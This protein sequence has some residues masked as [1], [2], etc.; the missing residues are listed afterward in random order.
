M[1]MRGEDKAGASRL[2]LALGAGLA[3]AA[4]AVIVICVARLLGPGDPGES[5]PRAVTGPDE[6]PPEAVAA[7]P[8]EPVSAVPA[9]PAPPDPEA[10]ETEWM[11]ESLLDDLNSPTRIVRMEAL[12]A[13]GRLAH[14]KGGE[15][16][17]P[18]LM[19]GARDEDSSVR[20]VAVRVLATVGPRA[21]P[22]VSLLRELVHDPVG[23]M[24]ARP[25]VQAL[26]KIGPAAADAVDDLTPLL[27]DNRRHCQVSSAEA[28]AAIGGK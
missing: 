13:L 1:R 25:A 6:G 9:V 26:G 21:A 3:V 24:V 20:C 16:V 7:H 14:R 4:L 12:Q 19:E 8:P 18:L 10:A 5:I 2:L 22:A 17:V 11:I 15:A 23:L 27:S 28:L